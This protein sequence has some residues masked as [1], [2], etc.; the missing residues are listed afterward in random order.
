[1]LARVQK[2]IDD[3][4][5]DPGRKRIRDASSIRQAKALA[6]KQSS[7]RQLV[8]RWLQAVPVDKWSQVR[9]EPLPGEQHCGQEQIEGQWTKVAYVMKDPSQCLPFHYDVESYDNCAI[10]MATELA[11]VAADGDSDQERECEQTS[12]VALKSVRE[13]A[14]AIKPMA[15]DD[16]LESALAATKEAE[17]ATVSN[18][19]DSSSDDLGEIGGSLLT[20]ALGMFKGPVSKPGPKFA[21]RSAQV[22]QSGSGAAARSS[23]SH[24]TGTAAGADEL[25][26]QCA[27]RP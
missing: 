16:L 23:Q 4:N 14:A 1:V 8:G 22:Q 27:S 5:M 21:P 18:A 2:Y 26:Q 12:K 3:A 24:A 11:K 20:Q 19:E 25:T 13:K 6:A 17:Q 15:L 7:G 10:E 9:T